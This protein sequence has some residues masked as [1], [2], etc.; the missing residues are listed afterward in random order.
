MGNKSTVF[1]TTF[2]N[3]TFLEKKFICIYIWFN[4]IKRA[5]YSKKIPIPFLQ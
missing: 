2:N 3:K 1:L 5:L 4:Y